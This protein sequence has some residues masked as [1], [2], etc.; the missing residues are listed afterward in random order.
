MKTLLVITSFIL[1]ALFP[2]TC[3]HDLDIDCSAYVYSFED[4]AGSYEADFI[5]MSEYCHADSIA[6][7]SQSTND[8]LHYILE[9]NEDG[10][11]RVYG[12]DSTVDLK[13]VVLNIT[14]KTGNKSGGCHNEFWI[15]TPIQ[16]LEFQL[17]HVDQNGME[18]YR[19]D[20]SWNFG[21]CD[22]EFIYTFNRVKR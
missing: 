18:L 12:T 2:V 6:P 17:F 16:K 10:N 22:R 13:W 8:S 11:G 7:V 5:Q 14:D 21:K 9:L 15:W 1:P 3:S 4:L 20:S 19:S